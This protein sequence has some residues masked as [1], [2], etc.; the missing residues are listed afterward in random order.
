MSPF[1]D[2]ITVIS[3][4]SLQ[5]STIEYAGTQLLSL[6]DNDRLVSWAGNVDGNLTKS[7]NCIE[8][9]VRSPTE[10]TN[11]IRINSHANFHAYQIAQQ[12]SR[13][14]LPARL[15]PISLWIRLEWLVEQRTTVTSARSIRR[16][17]YRHAANS[18]PITHGRNE[19]SLA[20]A[21]R[22]TRRWKTARR[23]RARNYASFN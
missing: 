1:T 11:R 23:C 6:T 9:R 7:R 10:F 19:P 4:D 20:S 13:I 8:A 22:Q 21:E 14:S 2:S 15:A 12:S 17:V 18:R 5:G 16:C 3:T